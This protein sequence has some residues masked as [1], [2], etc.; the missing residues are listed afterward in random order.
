MSLTGH[1]AG[2]AV[3]QVAEWFLGQGLEDVAATSL[4]EEVDGAAL[5]ELSE[6]DMR[7]TLGLKKLGPRKAVM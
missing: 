6:V 1:V 5:L 4:E 2:W 7:D 3:E